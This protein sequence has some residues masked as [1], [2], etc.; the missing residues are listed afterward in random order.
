MTDIEYFSTFDESVDMLRA[1]VDG[2]M[3][4]ILEP[5]LT[6]SPQATTY[7]AVDEVVIRS[8]ERSPGFYLAGSFTRHPI[9]FRQL[10]EGS[11]KGKYF[12]SVL[13]GGP[14]LQCQTARI[15]EVDGMPCLLP[16]Y[17]SHQD[18]YENPETGQW[19]KPTAELRT[20]FRKIVGLVKARCSSYEHE[21][22]AKVLITP[23]AR[24]KLEAKTV[25][26]A[27]G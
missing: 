26:I 11:A 4:L 22:G 15:G 18:T 5:E 10:T 24:A 7:G 27:A 16:G 9:A 17:F 20:A 6:D 12:I 3:H 1:L 25:A 21:P 8:L 2:G 23:A 14:I 13:S 19:E